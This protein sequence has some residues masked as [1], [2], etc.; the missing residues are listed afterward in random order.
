MLWC[1]FL[2]LFATFFCCCC[3]SRGSNQKTLKPRRRLEMFHVRGLETRL[4]EIQ[5]ISKQVHRNTSK[6]CS[7]VVPGVPPL[8]LTCPDIFGVLIVQ[9]IHS[10]SVQDGGQVNWTTLNGQMNLC[11]LEFPICFQPFLES[12][13]FLECVCQV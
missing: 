7:S 13:N 4:S 3:E 5:V 2:F 6:Y 11:N 10:V 12:V 1:L 8:R 9:A